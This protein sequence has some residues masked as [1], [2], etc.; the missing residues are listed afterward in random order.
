MFYSDSAFDNR[1]NACFV[2]TCGIEYISYTLQGMLRSRQCSISAL[3]LPPVTASNS[4][5]AEPLAKVI[6]IGQLV[7]DSGR[8]ACTACETATRATPVPHRCTGDT[9]KEEICS[10]RVPMREN[11]GR[12][13][14]PFT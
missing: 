7:F 6:A 14:N 9:A 4:Y 10:I 11:T 2:K 12:D 8:T 5:S 13:A 3:P 1:D